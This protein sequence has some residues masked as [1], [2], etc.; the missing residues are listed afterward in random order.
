MLFHLLGKLY[1]RTSVVITINLSFSEYPDAD[2]TGERP[3]RALRM[4]R[5]TR[6][7]LDREGNK[8]IDVMAMGCV[9]GQNTLSRC[10][11]NRQQTINL[12]FDA[13]TKDDF[14]GSAPYPPRSSFMSS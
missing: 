7:R 4:L 10:P 6:A 1:E 12:F 8:A 14:Q 3:H 9:A 13:R 5:P 11:S 2:Q